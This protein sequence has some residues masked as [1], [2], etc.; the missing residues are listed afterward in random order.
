MYLN[1]YILTSN[2]TAFGSLFTSQKDWIT[3]IKQKKDTGRNTR[4]D[5]RGDC[6]VHHRGHISPTHLFASSQCRSTSAKNTLWAW[7]NKPVCTSSVTLNRFSKATNF[8]LMLGCCRG[9]KQE[10]CG[11]TWEDGRGIDKRKMIA[12]LLPHL[13]DSKRSS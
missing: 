2:Q 1:T 4:A 13:S 7:Q 5:A 6:E 3:F 8:C 10:R 9:R 12:K 11:T